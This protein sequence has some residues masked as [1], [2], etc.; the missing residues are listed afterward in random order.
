MHIGIIRNSLV[1]VTLALCADRALAQATEV[2]AG[3]AGTA[4]FGPIV[5][6]KYVGGK[7]SQVWP[8]PIL[9][10]NY[11]ETFYV[12][13]Q[14]IGVY[15]IASDDKKT[16]L[17]LAVEPR[18]GYA[19]KDGPLLKNM[20]TRRN[21]IEGGPTFDWDIDVL[22]L[23]LAWFR[24]LDH[25]S[26]GQSLRATLYVPTLKNEQ[27]DLG[28]LLGADRMNKRV[29]NYYFGVTMPEATITRPAFAAPASTSV[30]IGF[31][32]TFKLDKR[33]ALIFGGNYAR[34]GSALAQSPL[35]ET[36]RAGTLY[37]GYG[38]TL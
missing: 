2:A 16:G 10:I 29:T 26:G 21:S 22:A 38:W 13:L 35:V 9:S 37:V 15:L 24:D 33:R 36:R 14:R 19:A 1:A 20:F 8:I 6:P 28:V 31:G 32:G 3:W 34:L 11:N 5:M 18:F 25:S 30:S 4:G 12:E 17:G 27:W 23:S 7:A